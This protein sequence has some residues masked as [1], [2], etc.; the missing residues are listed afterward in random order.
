MVTVLIVLVVFVVVEVF[1][2]VSGGSVGGSV[3]GSGSSVEVRE[4]VSFCLESGYSCISSFCRFVC[5]VSEV[6]GLVMGGLLSK[7]VSTCS[8]LSSSENERVLTK[9]PGGGDPFF[10][11][12]LLNLI[13]WNNQNEG[14]EGNEGN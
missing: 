1:N 12:P 2:S 3:G 5:C 14:N 7:S 10:I 4:K 9:P 6:V 8:L 11:L 13:Q